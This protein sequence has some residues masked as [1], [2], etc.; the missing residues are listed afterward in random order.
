MTEHDILQL[1]LKEIEDKLQ[2]GDSLNWTNREFTELSELLLEK[3]DIS[4]SVS[5]IRRLFGKSTDYK[6]VYNPQLDTKNALAI[7]LGYDNWYQ[8]RDTYTKRPKTKQTPLIVESTKKMYVKLIGVVLIGLIFIAI[9]QLF[10]SN[11]ETPQVENISLVGKNL[12]GNQIPHTTF[13]HYTV[14][15]GQGPFYIDWDDIPTD[16]SK[17]AEITKLENDSGVVSHTYYYKDL[18]D[19]RLLDENF[20]ELKKIQIIIHTDGWEG[21]A[22]QE[23]TNIRIDSMNFWNKDLLCADLSYL[24]NMGIDS[25]KPYRV[26]Y[27]NQSDFNVN[28][29]SFNF[30]MN[31]KPIFRQNFLDCSHVQIELRGNQSGHLISLSNTGCSGTIGTIYLS[32]YQ[33][34]GKTNDLSA[35]EVIDREWNSFKMDA[36]KDSTFLILN[37]D[38]ILKIASPPSIGEIVGLR[39]EFLGNGC[40]KDIELKSGIDSYVALN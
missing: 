21:F 36:K 16:A 3:T 11:E 25:I 10:Y 34:S 13:M 29:T 22:L 9:T 12:I 33:I 27:R 23:A 32:D 8:Y 18:Y 19:V 20:Q 5:S 38:T 14:P 37:N 24:Q 35:F 39:I 40:V 4:L 7:F 17:T 31:F 2:W 6:K 28:G 30:S 26:Y 15:K 1:C